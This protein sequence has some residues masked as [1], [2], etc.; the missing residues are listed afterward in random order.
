MVFKILIK[1]LTNIGILM[2]KARV[3]LDLGMKL[4]DFKRYVHQKDKVKLILLRRKLLRA[5]SR[6]KKITAEIGQVAEKYRG[7]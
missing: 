7:H 6:F 2:E 4:P 5:E 3:G 1:D